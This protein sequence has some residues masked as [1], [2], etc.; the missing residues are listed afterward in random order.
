MRPCAGKR[1]ASA[2]SVPSQ[3]GRSKKAAPPASATASTHARRESS[4][5]KKRSASDVRGAETRSGVPSATS[6]PRRSRSASR[7]ERLIEGVVARLRARGDEAGERRPGVDARVEQ[8]VA[9]ELDEASPRERVDLLPRQ[10]RALAPLARQCRLGRGTAGR[11]VVPVGPRR[12]RRHPSRHQEDDGAHPVPLQERRRDAPH[13]AAPVVEGEQHRSLGRRD[14]SPQDADVVVDRQR[15]VAVAGEV[16]ELAR[17]ALGLGPVEH[18]DRDL[19]ARERAAGDEGGVA[20]EQQVARDLP[21][22]ERA[23][24]QAAQGHRQLSRS[25]TS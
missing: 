10:Q 11:D 16:V 23:A 13:R 6:R 4:G 8:R 17:E 21:R 12:V 15:D 19:A 1:R 3:P 9:L 5:S 14:G 22:L 7:I 25:T 18:E 24:A 20:G 2:R